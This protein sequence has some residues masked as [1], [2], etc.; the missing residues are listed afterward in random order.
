[1]ISAKVLTIEG[2]AES[3][4]EVREMAD[5]AVVR[6]RELFDADSID[7]DAGSERGAKL[8]PSAF[9]DFSWLSIE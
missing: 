7:R 1:M 3:S 2:G 4:V 9:E 8:N 5:A 6:N